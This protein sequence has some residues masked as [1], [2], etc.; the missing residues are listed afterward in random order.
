VAADGVS[1]Q[2]IKEALLDQ[3]PDARKE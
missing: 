2:E 3:V 1:D